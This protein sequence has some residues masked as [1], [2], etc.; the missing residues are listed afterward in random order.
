MASQSSS[1]PQT[2][3]C[4]RMSVR[5]HPF[6]R[7]YVD[8]RDVST[9]RVGEAARKSGIKIL[10]SIGKPDVQ[11][12][13]SFVLPLLLQDVSSEERGKISGNLPENQQALLK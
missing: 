2:I 12:A 8:K 4:G 3:M 10:P 13:A 6:N 1:T 5:T 7:G 11:I 9:N